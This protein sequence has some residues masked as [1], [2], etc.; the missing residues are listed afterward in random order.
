M[1]CHCRRCC[2]L[3]F[4]SLL[5]SISLI[6]SMCIERNCS[7]DDWMWPFATSFHCVWGWPHFVDCF[8]LYFLCFLCALCVFMERFFCV[9]FHLFRLISC[10]IFACGWMFNHEAYSCAFCNRKVVVDAFFLTHF[11]LIHIYINSFFL[12]VFV[13]SMQITERRHISYKAKS[14][15]ELS[16]EK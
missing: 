8:V 7:L 9:S 14:W 15:N 12:C 10:Y 4:F 11:F 1:R 2:L 6:I 5:V 16:A 13:A 3:F